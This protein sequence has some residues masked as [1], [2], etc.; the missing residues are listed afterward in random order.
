VAVVGHVVA[1]PRPEPL[2]GGGPPEQEHQAYQLRR[3]ATQL[4]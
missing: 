4:L 2:V 1:L 3:E